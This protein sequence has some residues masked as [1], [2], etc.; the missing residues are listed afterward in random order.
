MV[1]MIKDLSSI[2]GFIIIFCFPDRGCIEK[3]F[4][5]PGIQKV[6]L[7]LTFCFL[8]IAANEKA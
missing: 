6:T 3:N 8:L 7:L 5:V 1:I 2:K 4:T